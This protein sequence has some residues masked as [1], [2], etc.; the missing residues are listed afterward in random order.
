[1]REPFRRCAKLDGGGLLDHADAL[2]IPMVSPAR[3]VEL[4][5]GHFHKQNP[6]DAKTLTCCQTNYPTSIST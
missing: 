5:I 3:A 4:R 1:M 6:Q 2:K